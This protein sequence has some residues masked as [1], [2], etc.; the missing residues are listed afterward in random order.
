MIFNNSSRSLRGGGAQIDLIS[1]IG[2]YADSV[3]RNHRSHAVY[4]MSREESSVAEMHVPLKLQAIVFK[5]LVSCGSI[6]SWQST[7][8][9]SQR[10]PSA[11]A[12]DFT[13]EKPKICL[14]RI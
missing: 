2:H 4:F 11:N 7:R 5:T 3:L 8:A 14:L 13:S 6:V 10:A 12:R 9:V 1:F